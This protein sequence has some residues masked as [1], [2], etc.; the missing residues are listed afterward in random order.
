MADRCRIAEKQ[1]SI[2]H[3][4][5]YSPSIGCQCQEIIPDAQIGNMLLGGLM[6]PLCP[7]I[8]NSNKQHMGF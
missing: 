8:I 5:G 7:S 2:R 4:S 3:L 6:Y 1:L